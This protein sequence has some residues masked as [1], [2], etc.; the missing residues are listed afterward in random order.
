MQ[1]TIFRNTE[2]WETTASGL[3]GGALRGP[4]LKNY[5]YYHE[6]FIVDDMFCH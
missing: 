2:I 4:S 6:L 3:L 5:Y 1:K